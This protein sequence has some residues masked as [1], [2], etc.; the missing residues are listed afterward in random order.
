MQNI[1]L[2]LTALCSLVLFFSTNLSAQQNDNT[3]AKTQAE[4]YFQ[5]QLNKFKMIS[6][7]ISELEVTDNY[8]NDRTGIRH[9]YL[10]QQYRGIPVRQGVA[11]LHVKEDGKVFFSTNKFVPR[12]A[13]KV[14]DNPIVLSEKQAIEAAARHLNAGTTRS[15]E[16]ITNHKKNKDNQQ[17]FTAAGVSRK[18]IPVRQYYEM[19]EAGQLRLVWETEIYMLTEDNW[20]VMRIDA[21]TGEEISRDNIIQHCRFGGNH[22]EHDHTFADVPW[23]EQPFV[24]SE[25]AA[26][27]TV[28]HQHQK[29]TIEEE[30]SLSFDGSY[31]HFRMPLESPLHADELGM[32]RTLVDGADIINST[33][34]PLGWHDNGN[35]QFTWT[36]GNNTLSY[37]YPEGTIVNTPA[38]DPVPQPFATEFPPYVGNVPDG[39]SELIFNYQNNLNTPNY[40]N[41]LADAIV[42]LFVWNNIMHDVTYLY[43]FN[44][45]SGNFQNNNFGLGGAEG[46]HVFAGAQANAFVNNAS[47]G[48][49][50][51][52]GNG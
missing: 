13:E 32:G 52:G 12:L 17:M 15:L 26:H 35:E 30:S 50:T 3:Q 46:D 1:R 24:N 40:N 29:E 31:F 7:D 42:N 27:S 6:S 4:Q 34:S 48:T 5:K 16:A 2:W 38:P 9:I 23:A 33:A 20:W 47:F 45:V 28:E 21:S 14:A 43:G 39:G 10:R 22:E 51:D 11:S 18:D 37:Y 49:P 8:V 41:F 44:E 36:E 19:N 25:V